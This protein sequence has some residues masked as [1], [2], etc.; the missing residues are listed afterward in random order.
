MNTAHFK[1]ITEAN[2]DNAKG[3]MMGV[4]YENYSSLTFDGKPR[5]MLQNEVN[6]V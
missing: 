2:K 1:R 4:I 6:E 5:I 3:A